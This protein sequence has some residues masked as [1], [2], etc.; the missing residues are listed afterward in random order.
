MANVDGHRKDANG[1]NPIETYVQADVSQ[2]AR[3]F[4]GFVYKVDNWRDYNMA[5]TPLIVDATIN[6]SGPSTFLGKTISG[7]GMAGVKAA[8]DHIFAHPNVAPF[9][10]KQLIQ[11]LVTSNPTPGYVG[12][13]SAVFADN[14]KGVRGD[15]GAVVK[16]ILLDTEARSDA[17]LT[18]TTAGRLRP[19]VQRL[20]AWARAANVTSATNGWAIGDTSSSASGI[21]QAVGHS[22]SVF[23]FFRPGYTPPGSAIAS[24]NLVAPEFQV[25]NEQSVV[26]YVNFMYKAVDSGIGDVKPDY[27]AFTTKAGDAK[28]LVDEVSLVLAGGQLSS[29]SVETITAAVQSASSPDA[30][31]R[32]AFLLTLTAPEFLTTR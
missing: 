32:I 4:T 16:A 11:R 27:S 15:L 22:P 30:R 9:V 20:T 12:R 3:V 6:E 26:S 31:V 5:R 18:S 29:R 24:A 25:A 21:G 7:G 13:V 28:A 2:L 14:G 23:N 1:G 10:S 8:L 19:P 17:A